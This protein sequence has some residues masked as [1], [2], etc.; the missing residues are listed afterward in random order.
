MPDY[1][2]ATKHTVASVMYSSHFLDWSNEPS[3][4]R[5]YP[6]APRV[7]LARRPA[8]IPGGTLATIAALGEPARDVGLDADSL[9]SFLFHSVAISAWKEVATTGFRYSL[10]VDP[11]SGN[12]HPTETWLALRG[13]PGF[14]DGLWHYDVR[15]HA[16]ERRRDGDAVGAIARATGDASIG[17]CRAVAVLSS[18]FWR[19]AWKYRDR[20]FRYCLH[21]A[22]HVAGSLLVAARALGFRGEARGAFDD[23]ALNAALAIAADDG[24]R[25][26]LVLPLREATDTAPAA[27]TGLGPPLGEPEPRRFEWDHPAIEESSARAEPAAVPGPGARPLPSRRDD[28]LAAVTRRRRSALGFDPAAR[29]PLE[30]F[31]ALLAHATHRP[32]S[33]FGEPLVAL[34]PF[35]HAIDGLAPGAYRHD[36]R[37][38][39]L[40]LV[41]AGDQ[42][43]TAMG[44]SLSQEIAGDA[45]AAFAMAADLL[46]ARDA[47]GGRGY[48]YA[49][50][51]AGLIG[52]LLY[53][54][55]EALGLNA[56]GIGAF[57]DDDVN[58]H[59]ALAAPATQVVY[60]FAVGRAVPDPRLVT[61]TDGIEA[62]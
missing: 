45:V 15:A 26:L 36:A 29:M 2:D 40:A 17:A 54:G 30:D 35:A 18:I 53:L 39:E 22:G 57:Y 32:P 10:R 8:P 47:A 16:L 59:L 50:M 58:R 34:H 61:V 1:H 24:E 4:F 3:P 12:L 25:A 43:R 55:A 51:E 13:V 49:L 44:L 48:R 9:A 27:S 42:R 14:D 6:G 20:A 41:V 33:D 19:E 7:A 28:E 52:Q 46:R 38:G 11:S 56:T 31:A 5:A 62:E 23:R 37:T 60:H 21:D